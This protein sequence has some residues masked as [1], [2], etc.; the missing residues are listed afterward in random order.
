MHLAGQHTT[1]CKPLR[2]GLLKCDFEMGMEAKVAPFSGLQAC[3]V[4]LCT[5]SCQCI[6]NLAGKFQ[7][8]SFMAN[9]LVRD[10]LTGEIAPSICFNQIPRI[11]YHAK[12]CSFQTESG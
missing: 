10:C 11:A 4:I 7:N 2:K 9:D 12:F 8:S 6:E 5:C 1:T 3:A